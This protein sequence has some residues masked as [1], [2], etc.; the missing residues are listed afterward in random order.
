V[1]IEF[2]RHAQIVLEERKICE[3]WIHRTLESADHIEKQGDGTIHYL[4]SIPEY[5]ERF[6]RVVVNPN[7]NPRKIV[8]LFFD[9]RIRRGMQ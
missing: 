2:S 8:T 4:K 6:L 5:G 1:N 7:K 3:A 9:R